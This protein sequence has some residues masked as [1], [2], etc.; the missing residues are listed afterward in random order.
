MILRWRRRREALRAM[1]Q[2]DGE[3]W[4]DQRVRSRRRRGAFGRLPYFPGGL[5]NPYLRLLYAGL[6]EVGLDASPLGQYELLDQMPGSSV[7]HLHWT[8]VF[9]VGTA[10]E[11]EARRQSDAYVSKIEG[12]LGRGGR[13]LWSVHEW[14]PHDCEFPEVEVGLRRRL[15]ELASGVHVLH[16]STVG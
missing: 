5:Q 16:G 12:F 10:S 2:V 8:R 11:A 7:F 13:L 6:P 4:S 14:L 3:V 1:D 9:Q 15:V